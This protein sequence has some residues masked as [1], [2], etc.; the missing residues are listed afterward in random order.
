MTFAQ[1]T[2]ASSR[3]PRPTTCEPNVAKHLKLEPKSKRARPAGVA[4]FVLERSA[5]HQPASRLRTGHPGGTDGKEIR[6]PK[7]NATCSCCCTSSLPG[8][9]QADERSP[10]TMIDF[11]EPNGDSS[12]ARTVRPA[13]GGGRA[14]DPGRGDPERPA[15]HVPVKPEIYN[16]VLDELGDDED[17]LRREGGNSRKQ[18]V[19]RQKTEV[20]TTW[21][22]RPTS[23]CPHTCGACARR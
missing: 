13:G 10:R 3:P 6:T 15:N 21:H 16:P 1:W 14:A 2:R 8:S 5:A 11:G 12:M 20:R 9:P 17:P 19:R 23:V 4:G 22:D 18:E 7:A